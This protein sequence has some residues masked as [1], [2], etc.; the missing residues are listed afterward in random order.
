LLAV[1]P[2]PRSKHRSAVHDPD[3]GLRVPLCPVRCRN[4]ACHQLRRYLAR[5]DAAQALVKFMS[6]PEAARGLA[7]ARSI[8]WPA[9]CLLPRSSLGGE[10]LD[11]GDRSF[12]Q[13]FV[14]L[15]R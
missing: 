2:S 5:R 14:K 15:D 8:W 10:L 3:H 4:A 1:S 6:S 11:L 13:A 12:V 9:L 7:E